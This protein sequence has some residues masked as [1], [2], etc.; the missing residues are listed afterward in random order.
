MKLS[1][2]DRY[3][4]IKQAVKTALDPQTKVVL[5]FKVTHLDPTLKVSGVYPNGFKYVNPV[6]AFFAEAGAQSENLDELNKRVAGFNSM[7][8]DR[9]AELN[10]MDRS[11]FG[12]L[13]KPVRFLPEELPIE[14]QPTL[15]INVKL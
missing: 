13:A 9:Y 15:E 6:I 11:D 14:E 4:I 3:K 2:L 7:T 10:G 8:V 12:V 1:L 5:T